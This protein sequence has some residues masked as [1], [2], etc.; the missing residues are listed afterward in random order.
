M[1]EA[2]RKLEQRVR[3]E[4]EPAVTPEDPQPPTSKKSYR[5]YATEDERVQAEVSVD[6]THARLEGM[7]FDFSFGAAPTPEPAA[8]AAAT[9]LASSPPSAADA[10][11]AA[12]SPQPT[13]RQSMEETRK[14]LEARVTSESEPNSIAFRGGLKRTSSK[15][16]ERDAMSIYDATGLL[17]ATVDIAATAGSGDSSD[18]GSPMSPE[19]GVQMRPK[20][21]STAGDAKSKHRRSIFR[22]N[23][24]AKETT[25][26]SAS[27]EPAPAAAASP[28]VQASSAVQMRSPA[29][30]SKVRQLLLGV[31]CTSH[32]LLL[33]LRRPPWQQRVHGSIGIP[34]AA[35]RQ[36]DVLFPFFPFEFT[37]R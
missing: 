35:L 28:E 10:D 23:K 16:W 20:T 2:R 6:D 31:L 14:K 9:S 7:T 29:D 4:T 36:R 21:G 15:P 34:A 24:K 12:P 19:P 17:D 11:I 18:P 27:P 37:A 32:A 30:K 25:A 1:G 26:A 5:E 33:L 3:A 8:V 13:R 22:R